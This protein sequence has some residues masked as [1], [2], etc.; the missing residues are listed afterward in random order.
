[1]AD[2]IDIHIGRRIRRRRL[3]LG[4][5]QM[6]LAELCDIKFQQIQKY[7]CAANRTSAARLWQIAVNLEVPVSYFFEG[8]GNSVD[9]EEDLSSPR[10]MN[11]IREFLSKKKPES[12]EV[13]PEEPE[14]I[15]RSVFSE[16][17][18]R[19]MTGSMTR[20]TVTTQ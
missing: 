1:V 7:E 3:I 16:D 18:Y 12:K 17:L 5:T 15:S 20:A 14:Q 6:Y 13:S 10:N 8:L 2:L 4:W 11:E 19:R 9:E